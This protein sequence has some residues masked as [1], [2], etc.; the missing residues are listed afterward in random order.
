MLTEGS[1]SAIFAANIVLRVKTT[2]LSTFDSWCTIAKYHVG[3]C[4]Y[5]LFK[6]WIMSLYK[7]R[8]LKC[9]IITNI[10]FSSFLLS[11]PGSRRCWSDNRCP[12]V[13]P[14]TPLSSHRPR[15][16]TMARCDVT[17]P[18]TNPFLSGGFTA[19]PAPH[20]LDASPNSTATMG[21]VS[22]LVGDSG[23]RGGSS[24]ISDITNTSSEGQSMYY[25][26]LQHWGPPQITPIS[27]KLEKVSQNK[28]WCA[29]NWKFKF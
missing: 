24:R 12:G 5:L 23:Y 9:W 11:N 27:G 18:Q 25:E 7:Y 19:L 8:C 13:H 2:S 20:S 10:L 4:P 3:A 15:P 14:A 26:D 6:C 16:P 1:K 17:L 21:S 22:S 28:I 29:Q